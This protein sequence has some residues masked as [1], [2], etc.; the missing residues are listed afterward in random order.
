MD[1]TSCQSSTSQNVPRNMQTQTKSAYECTNIR[2]RSVSLLRLPLNRLCS[3]A[4]G[5]VNGECSAL[6]GRC[7]A[8]S[9]SLASSASA[10]RRDAGS[11]R[12]ALLAS[13]AGYLLA[14]HLLANI[15]LDRAL[16]TTVV[17]R[18]WQ[19][20]NMLVFVYVGPGVHGITTSRPISYPFP[21]LAFFFQQTRGFVLVCIQKNG[22]VAPGSRVFSE[23]WTTWARRNKERDV[24]TAHN[25]GVVVRLQGL[26]F[27]SFHYSEAL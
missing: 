18:F 23:R 15:D 11:L 7:S 19:Q 26:C 14:F 3:F 5:V 1:L 17:S 16:F 21:G 13:W 8:S 6:V 20:P 10:R 22:F 24:L 27:D 12:W 2:L 25:E 4:S 9:A